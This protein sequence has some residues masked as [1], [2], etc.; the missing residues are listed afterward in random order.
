[1]NRG[2]S[3]NKGNFK[4][5]VTPSNNTVKVEVPAGSK[6]IIQLINDLGFGDLV[7]SS[8]GTAKDSKRNRT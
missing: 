1:M 7:S 2:S 8:Q 4:L 6:T 3:S 5:S